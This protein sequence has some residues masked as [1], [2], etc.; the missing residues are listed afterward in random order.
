MRELADVVDT[1]QAGS[2]PD[3][4]DEWRKGW[5]HSQRSEQRIVQYQALQS[6]PLSAAWRIQRKASAVSPSPA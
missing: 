1:N 2:L 5:V 4:A 6:R 3:A